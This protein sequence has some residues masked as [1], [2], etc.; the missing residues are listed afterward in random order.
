MGYDTPSLVL[1]HLHAPRV[2]ANRRKAGGGLQ[3]ISGPW[4]FVLYFPGISRELLS[5]FP[6]RKKVMA[7]GGEAFA[8]KLL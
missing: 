7:G 4:G 5:F 6:H 2:R 1:P 8:W 3:G